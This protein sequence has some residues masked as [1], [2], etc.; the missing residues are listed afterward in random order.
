MQQETRVSLRSPES[1]KDLKNSVQLLVKY[2]CND[3]GQVKYEEVS[4][5]KLKF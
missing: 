3:T 5:P 4:E 1:I 2:Q